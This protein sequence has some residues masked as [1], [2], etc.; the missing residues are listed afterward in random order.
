M[1][2]QVVEE[3]RE[4]E[5][6]PQPLGMA[7][8]RQVLL[9]GACFGSAMAALYIGNKYVRDAAG[10]PQYILAHIPFFFLLMGE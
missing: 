4:E 10:N 8:W 9:L 7:V 3:L 2:L 5:A 1:C 6:R